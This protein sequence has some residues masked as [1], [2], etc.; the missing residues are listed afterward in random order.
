VA[1]DSY[2]DWR[3][4][5]DWLVMGVPVPGAVEPA[6]AIEVPFQITVGDRQ[7]RGY[8]DRVFVHA[9]TGQPLVVD[10]KSG[11]KPDSD[12][13]LAIYAKALREMGLG[14]FEWGAYYYAM[15]KGGVLTNFINLAHWTDE[16]FEDV[17]LPGG[18]II[19]REL[20]VPKPGKACFFC[21]VARHCRYNRSAT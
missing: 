10:L 11:V 17:Y 1:L 12:A 5:T 21:T 6:P 16:M 20:F 2:I 13:Q 14:E 8:I 15:K 3:L 19:E 9:K 18:E 7:V 4:S